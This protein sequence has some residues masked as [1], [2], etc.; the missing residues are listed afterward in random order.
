MNY[1]D[2]KMGQ[3]TATINSHKIRDLEEIIKALDTAFRFIF[4]AFSKVWY[5]N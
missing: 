4:T 5:G 2:K 3:I 1:I